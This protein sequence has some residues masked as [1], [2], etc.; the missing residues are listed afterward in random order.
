MTSETMYAEAS[1]STTS[2]P[3]PSTTITPP[4]LQQTTFSIPATT[5]QPQQQTPRTHS[6]EISEPTIGGIPNH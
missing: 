3:T 6:Y 1:A 2:A 4:Y 5:H